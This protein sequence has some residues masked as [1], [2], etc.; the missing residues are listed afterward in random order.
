MMFTCQINPVLLAKMNVKN[1]RISLVSLVEFDSSKKVL[2][3]SDGVNYRLN[4]C[5]YTSLC[6][7]DY[8][9]MLIL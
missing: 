4:R 1:M 5:H 9:H 8:Y 7:F 3:H 6:I 2:V